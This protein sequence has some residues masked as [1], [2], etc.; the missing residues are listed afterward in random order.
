MTGASHAS[1]GAALG[2]LIRRPAL[3]FLAGA[4][5]HIVTDALPHRDLPLRVEVALLGA[6]IGFIAAR[7][8]ARSPQFW[9]AVG[10]VAPDME[11]ALVELGI[12]RAEDEVFP[13][14]AWLGKYHGPPSSGPLSQI[15]AFVAG[16]LIAEWP[17]RGRAPTKNPEKSW[18]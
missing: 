1:I 12:I 13:S 18:A 10:A 9:G 14:H 2:A 11:H 4:A 5:S 15:A 6:T 8:G 7:H 16:L 3:A 17:Q